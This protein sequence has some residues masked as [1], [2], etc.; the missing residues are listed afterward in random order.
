M[1]YQHQYVSFHIYNPPLVL[2]MMLL[3]LITAILLFI[4]KRCLMHTHEILQ[5]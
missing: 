4:Y 2:D 5:E 1:T 3:Y